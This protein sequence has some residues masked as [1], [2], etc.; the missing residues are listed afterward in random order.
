[1]KGSIVT[2][3]CVVVLLNYVNGQNA[4]QGQHRRSL[5]RVIRA[6]NGL[7][8]NT[9]GL[10]L[11]MCIDMLEPE[12]K[13]AWD[14]CL[15]TENFVDNNNLLTAICASRRN[16]RRMRNCLL[17]AAR[18]NWRNE[19]SN[20]RTI[21]RFLRR[22]ERRILRLQMRNE[23]FLPKITAANNATVCLTILAG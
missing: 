20:I 10:N 4:R 23:Y 8:G 15:T 22:R 12:D 7:C 6:F 2:I 14:N 1:M 3:V 9:T 17:R 11:D 13:A 18:I 19:W 5:R 21:T 16:F